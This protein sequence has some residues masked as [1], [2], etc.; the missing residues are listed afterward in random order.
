M[1]AFGMC[2][3]RGLYRTNIRLSAKL[4]SEADLEPKVLRGGQ[5]AGKALEQDWASRDRLLPF[6]RT[7]DET[8][9]QHLPPFLD[10][11]SSRTR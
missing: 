6:D 7:F 2:D 4:V 8:L 10:F 5:P 3:H 11:T 1:L 9:L